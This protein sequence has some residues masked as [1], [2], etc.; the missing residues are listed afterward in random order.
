M[1]KHSFFLWSFIMI[2]SRLKMNL[3]PDVKLTTKMWLLGLN[4][5]N[6]S[7]ITNLSSDNNQMVWTARAT[8]GFLAW[9][10]SYFKC[11]LLCYDWDHPQCPW[12]E[13]WTELKKNIENSNKCVKYSGYSVVFV[14]RLYVFNSIKARHI[15]YFWLSFMICFIQLPFLSWIQGAGRGRI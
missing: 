6:P 14:Y 2:H 7:Q 15:Q 5:V 12:D 8:S 1:G 9:P 11:R 3:F 13:L 4:T 10:S